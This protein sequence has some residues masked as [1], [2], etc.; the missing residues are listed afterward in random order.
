MLAV[1]AEIHQELI[2]SAAPVV[3][4]VVDLVGHS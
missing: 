2:L 1:V 3:M 4:V